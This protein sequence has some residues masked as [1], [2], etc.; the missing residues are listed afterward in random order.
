MRCARNANPS[1]L[2]QNKEKKTQIISQR[3]IQVIC[4]TSW[5]RHMQYSEVSL[6]SAATAAAANVR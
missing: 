4:I 5:T 6:T 3:C 2:S 1:W